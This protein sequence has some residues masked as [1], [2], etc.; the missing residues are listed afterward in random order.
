M[1]EIIFLTQI[2]G[3]KM[4]NTGQD[5]TEDYNEQYKLETIFAG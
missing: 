1:E 5:D 4:S 2:T 3:L